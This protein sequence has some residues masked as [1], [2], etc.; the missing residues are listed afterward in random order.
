M[1]PLSVSLIL[2]RKDFGDFT[3]CH[4]QYS[5]AAELASK[6]ALYLLPHVLDF[7]IANKTIDKIPQKVYNYQAIIEGNYVY[8]G[9][10]IHM[11]TKAIRC[12]AYP[13]F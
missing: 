8:K 3:Y 4:A 6:L 7:I 11:A 12:K 9:E 10:R 13:P 1:P 5:I 2:L